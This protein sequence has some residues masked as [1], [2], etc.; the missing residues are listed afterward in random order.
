MTH[1]FGESEAL[2][3]LKDAAQTEPTIPSD[4]QARLMA[5]VSRDVGAIALGQF[6]AM[7]PLDATTTLNATSRARVLASR[8]G[9]W[10]APALVIGAVAGIMGHAAFGKERTQIVYVDRTVSAAPSATPAEAEAL[11]PNTE[12]KDAREPQPAR[13]VT[14]TPATESN[15]GAVA[16]ARSESPLARERSLLDPAR[17]D[18]AAGE[19]VRALERTR[20]HS[21]EFPNGLL[22]EEREAIAINA[23]VS[24]GD[25]SQA[26]KRAVAFR[27]RFP[28]SLMA[29]FVDAAMAAVPTE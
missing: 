15:T 28:R 24:L 6:G 13:V 21:K 1:P 16:S 7:T 5:R 3:W 9:L 23:L 14:A 2:D 17:A 26:T 19:P 27:A 11:A 20:R 18:L 8:I 22:S 12:T 29:H 4:V 25:Y 10:S